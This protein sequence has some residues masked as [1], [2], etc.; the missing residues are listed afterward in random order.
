MPDRRIEHQLRERERMGR[1]RAFIDPPQR[2]TSG[3]GSRSRSSLR[4]VQVTLE[5]SLPGFARTD[6]ETLMEKARYICSVCDAKREEVLRLK[7]V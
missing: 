7:L 3:H 5:V 6:A 4:S 1:A 2:D